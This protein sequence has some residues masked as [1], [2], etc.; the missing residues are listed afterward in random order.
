MRGLRRSSS[1]FAVRT[2][3]SV[4]DGI[5]NVGVEST[6]LILGERLGRKPGVICTVGG[7]QSKEQ[8]VN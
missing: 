8:G 4:G 6:G 5:E 1:G 2:D 3:G 7:R